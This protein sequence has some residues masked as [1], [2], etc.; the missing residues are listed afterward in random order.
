MKRTKKKKRV[1]LST[2]E[3]HHRKKPKLTPL[4]VNKRLFT[5]MEVRMPQNFHETYQNVRTNLQGTEF[6]EVS[7]VE[8]DAL[9]YRIRKG[10]TRIEAKVRLYDHTFSPF[11][12]P[13]IIKL[14]YNHR[15][16]FEDRPKIQ[17]VEPYICYEA[18]LEPAKDNNYVDYYVTKIIK[19]HILPLSL[20]NRSGGYD[21][22]QYIFL[23]ELEVPISTF[24]NVYV[25]K[26]RQR[27]IGR[28]GIHERTLL[29]WMTAYRSCYWRSPHTFY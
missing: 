22:L 12:K 26:I 28:T 23:A 8:K 1:G 11:G 9:S 5:V 3:R 18:I 17:L 10:I 15:L 29:C 16:S 14:K 25:K 7:G 19:I 13:I 4:A 27:M 2:A 20:D 6:R 24:R 21:R